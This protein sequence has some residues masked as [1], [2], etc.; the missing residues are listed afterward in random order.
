MKLVQESAFVIHK[1]ISPLNLV[2]A[3][4]TFTSSTLFDQYVSSGFGRR[5]MPIVIQDIHWHQSLHKIYLEVPMKDVRPQKLDI[6][7]TDSYLKLHC[8]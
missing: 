2:V 8:R 4:F 3:T 5:T 7:R 1:Y 6:L